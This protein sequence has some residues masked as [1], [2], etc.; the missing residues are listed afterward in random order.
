MQSC[1]LEVTGSVL[2]HSRKQVMSVLR[3]AGL[4]GRTQR[5]GGT[6]DPQ[7]CRVQTGAW[8]QRMA[9]RAFANG[10]NLSYYCY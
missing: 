5:E 2:A 6:V 8:G 4:S 1:A 3:G 10:L 9:T 7:E